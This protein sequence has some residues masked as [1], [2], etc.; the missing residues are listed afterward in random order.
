MGNAEAV[1]KV[2]MPMLRKVKHVAIL[3]ELFAHD[4]L[5]NAIVPTMVAMHQAV[6]AS[7]CAKITHIPEVIEL[8][9][10]PL[11]CRSEKLDG[12]GHTA[13]QRLSPQHIE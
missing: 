10:A 13:F 1:K 2:V 6:K 11:E 8:H 3:T 7:G 12:F 9:A 5:S 4:M